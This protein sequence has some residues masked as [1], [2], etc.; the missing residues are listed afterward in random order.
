MIEWA[1]LRAIES[2][3]DTKLKILKFVGLLIRVEVYG[4]KVKF[5]LKFIQILSLPLKKKKRFSYIQKDIYHFYILF[6]LHE[7]YL[8]VCTS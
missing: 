1:T 7:R 3:R 6:F 5:P 8:S 4:A 2:R